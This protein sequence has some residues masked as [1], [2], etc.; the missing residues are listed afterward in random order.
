MSANQSPQDLA[1]E[2]IHRLDELEGRLE[3]YQD[4]VRKALTE[5][6]PHD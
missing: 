5:G 2:I 6:V 4:K 3:L 1:R